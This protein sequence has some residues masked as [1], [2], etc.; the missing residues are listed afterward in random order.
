MAGSLSRGSIKYLN[1]F[2]ISTT[3]HLLFNLIFLFFGNFSVLHCDTTHRMEKNTILKKNALMRNK[4]VWFW[5]VHL[6]CIV[7]WLILCPE[8]FHILAGNPSLTS[9]TV[10]L[11]LNSS[12]QNYVVHDILC[13]QVKFGV[14]SL[15]YSKLAQYIN[16]RHEI[17]EGI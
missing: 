17:L 14:Y 6:I 16:H 8:Y 15:Y 1:S 5:P 3:S 13:E 9:N 11:Y 10:V 12:L 4:M 2:F 7:G